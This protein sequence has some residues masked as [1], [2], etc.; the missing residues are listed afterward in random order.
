MG[1]RSNSSA[2]T[3]SGRTHRAGDSQSTELKE[4]SDEHYTLM[5]AVLTLTPVPI[6]S[7]AITSALTPMLLQ[8]TLC[9]DL[10]P[11]TCTEHD[12]GPEQ[13]RNSTQAMENTDELQ[14]RTTL[15]T[16]RNSTDT[17]AGDQSTDREWR[18]QT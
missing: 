13:Q 2:G 10:C 12:L 15:K 1:Y 18:A 14:D 16:G 9:G 5:Y 7:P 11:N 8:E 17:T 4:V 6:R 3:A